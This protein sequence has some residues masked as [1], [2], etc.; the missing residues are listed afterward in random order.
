MK[1]QNIG[2]S[3]PSHVEEEVMVLQ[4]RADQNSN[5]R[6]IKLIGDEGS[7]YTLYKVYP[8]D[9]AN[10]NP[11]NPL[12]AR[13]GGGWPQPVLFTTGSRKKVIRHA[14]YENRENWLSFTD[15][16]HAFTKKGADD[17]AYQRAKTIAE[18]VSERTN[19]P[20]IE[21]T[22]RYSSIDKL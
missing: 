18:L 2:V 22:S 19:L 7:D 5:G 3:L 9:S 20:L 6:Y 17:K 11:K 15:F 10:L 8:V 1:R 14:A 12:D 4:G 16:G 21:E 13:F